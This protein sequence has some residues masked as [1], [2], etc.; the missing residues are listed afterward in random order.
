[1]TSPRGLAVRVRLD[2]AEIEPVLSWTRVNRA[3]RQDEKFYD[4]NAGFE[5]E[6]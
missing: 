2:P 5:E 6:R 1:V 3:A 4:P